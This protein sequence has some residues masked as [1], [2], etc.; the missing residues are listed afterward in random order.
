MKDAAKPENAK[1]QPQQQDY[2]RVYG[3]DD[4]EKK[5]ALDRER[6]A[7]TLTRAPSVVRAH[8][9]AHPIAGDRQ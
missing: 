8:L 1:V 5:H 2:S 4:D 7:L 9:L 3:G 6:F